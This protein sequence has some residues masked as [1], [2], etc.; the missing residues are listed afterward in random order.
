MEPRPPPHP[1]PWDPARSPRGAAQPGGGVTRPPP[2]LRARGAGRWGDSEPQGKGAARPALGTG[3]K[4]LR[5]TPVPGAS[6]PSISRP[7]QPPGCRS[8][9]CPGQSH[10]PCPARATPRAGPRSRPCQ[11]PSVLPA[12][13][14]EGGQLST[15]TVGP[16]APGARHT[17]LGPSPRCRDQDR[18]PGGAA[19]RGGS[20]DASRGAPGVAPTPAPPAPVCG[21]A[22]PEPEVALG[23][24]CGGAAWRSLRHEW[25]G[26]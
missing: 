17:A 9:H 1:A 20:W 25:N 24:A 19:G 15:C 4:A 8:G 18:P 11:L 22:G 12:A 21:R 23:A 10:C 7:C 14:R 2:W 6:A 26:P 3:C 5:A 16:A 13:A